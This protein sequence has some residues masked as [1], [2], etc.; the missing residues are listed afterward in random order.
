ML[1]LII[2]KMMAPSEAKTN[3]EPLNPQ[4]TAIG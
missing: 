3:E 4:V 2:V 1:G